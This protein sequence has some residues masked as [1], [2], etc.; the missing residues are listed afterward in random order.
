M[1][2]KMDVLFE[3]VKDLV[4]SDFPVREITP[5]L[6]DT[7]LLEIFNKLGSSDLPILPVI[8]K[9]N[10]YIGIIT[11]RD[12]LFLFQRRHTSLTEVVSHQNIASKNTASDLININ[13]P[14]IYDEDSLERIVE[15][16]SKSQSTVLPRASKRNEQITGLLYV[17]DI[18][19]EI[20]NMLRKMASEGENEDGH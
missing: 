15:I 5:I 12:L 6:E 3:K 10:E 4:A 11:L 19:T 9:N 16:M 7:P 8:D 13:L 18:F 1:N 14:I 17:K 2:I 20:R